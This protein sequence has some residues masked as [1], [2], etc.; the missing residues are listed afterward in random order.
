MKEEQRSSFP[1][2]DTYTPP[3]G[4]PPSH[5]SQCQLRPG[6]PLGRNEY[7]S[8]PGPPPGVDEVLLPP[9]PLL[10]HVTVNRESDP[11]PYYDWTSV[12]DTAL[13]PPPPSIGHEHS[14][15]S[16]ADADEADRAHDWCK[17]NPLVKPHLPTEAQHAAT[18]NGDVRL[19]KPK[20]YRGDLSMSGTG[21]WKGSTR[22]GSN[23]VCLLTSAPLYFASVDSPLRT[24]RTKTIYFEVNVKSLGRGP[25]TEDCAVAIGYCG[26]PYPT[27]R[28]PGWER[29]SLAV[30]SDD[31]RRYVNDTWGGKDFT[32]PIHPGDA[33]GLAMTFSIPD[34][35][36]EY[37]SKPQTGTK[38]NVEIAFTRNGQED[39]AWNL[40]EELDEETDRGVDGLG[41]FFDLYGAVGVFGGTEF[42]VK[43]K[44]DEWLWHPRSRLHDRHSKLIDGD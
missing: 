31:G 1:A 14:S 30:H 32:S 34:A 37:G 9:S 16:N 35:P 33:I 20:E 8:P 23:D 13:L 12:P 18:H 42:D 38:I 43:F 28:M 39:N 15:S 11:P 10:S 26:M 24:G 27:W 2:P 29:G 41:G 7:A 3:S 4:P 36:P 17:A 40:H 5:Q 44:R 19:M 25:G 6:P 21:S 22:T